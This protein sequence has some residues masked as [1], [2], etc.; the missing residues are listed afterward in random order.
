MDNQLLAGFIARV[1]L[2]FLFFFQGYD[3]LFNV[4][5]KNVVETYS[6]AF[7]YK[8][9]PRFITI[10]G[11]WYTSLIEFIG[12]LLLI[13]GVF[14]HYTLYLLGLDLILASIAFGISKP[15]WDMRFVFPRLVLLLFL[16]VIPNSWNTISLDCLFAYLYNH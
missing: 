9:I 16:L 15:M 8:G 11:A 14:Q 3:A 10:T 4:K 7:A 13:L 12:G 6:D 2:G 1:F 5:I